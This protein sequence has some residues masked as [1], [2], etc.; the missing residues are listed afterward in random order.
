M[1]ADEVAEFQKQEPYATNRLQDRY[2]RTNLVR[3]D[4]SERGR[5]GDAL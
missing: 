2:D 4:V 3:T 5:H 1:A